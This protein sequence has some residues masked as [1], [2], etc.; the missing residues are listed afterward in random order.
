[1]GKLT[2]VGLG[3]GAKGITLEGMEAIKEADVAYLEYYTTPHEAT[4]LREIETAT[5]RELTVVDRG[6]VEDGKA[7]LSEARRSRVVL[8]VQGDPMIATTHN[9]LRARA[10]NSGIETVILHAATIAS[11]A[12][13]ASGL[14]Y[15]KF[16]GTITVTRE[17]VDV[18]Q[19]VYQTLHRNLLFGIHTLLLL[20]AKG[21]SN[22]GVT[23]NGAIGGLL[24]AERNFKRAVISDD[25]FGIVLSR[26]G[27][28]DFDAKAGTLSRLRQLDF[29]NQP[30]SLII[31]ARLHFTEAEA[32]RSIF[33][34]NQD[35]IRDNA[36][37]VRRSA[38]VLVPRYVE[39]TR[40]A[41]ADAREH[42]GR[43]Y[44]SLVEN[45][46]SYISDAERFLTNGEDELAMLSVGYAEGL[47]DSLALTGKVKIVW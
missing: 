23:P 26:V 12:A 4:L 38:E 20:E 30:H 39:K 14:H 34:L 3:L 28:A 46:E 42:L 47:L 9:D 8:A 6:Y 40:K 19:Q 31:P 44:E 17:G 32:V 35:E 33:S 10:I 21:E 18:M 36:G 2:F 24:Q 25:T 43:E 29:G 13:S 11:S 5:G 7:I 15:Y 22:E 41:L 37:G 16:G 45:V 1:M 27:R